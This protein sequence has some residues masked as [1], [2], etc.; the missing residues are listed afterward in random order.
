VLN[1]RHAIAD[2]VTGFLLGVAFMLVL[3]QVWGLGWVRVIA[4]GWSPGL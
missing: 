3:I 4:P 1:V 2:A